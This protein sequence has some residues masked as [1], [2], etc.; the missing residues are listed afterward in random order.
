MP[1]Q[2]RSVREDTRK[3]SSVCVVLIFL[4]STLSFQQNIRENLLRSARRNFFDASS[5]VR[6]LLV[7]I[8]SFEGPSTFFLPCEREGPP[9]SSSLDSA[10]CTLPHSYECRTI[11]E[12]VHS[13][14]I[15]ACLDNILGLVNIRCRILPIFVF[16][17]CTR[18]RPKREI[19]QCQEVQRIYLRSSW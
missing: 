8:S 18:F 17:G 4:Q 10:F 5:A 7:S 15:N 2:M 9:V 11:D 14:I 1:V 19:L 12:C 3:R 6:R 13:H 16:S